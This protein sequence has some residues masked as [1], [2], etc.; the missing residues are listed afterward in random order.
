M[1]TYLITW[2]PKRWSWE[3]LS[4]EAELVR[5]DGFVDD[6]WSC[7]RN[8]K[9]QK[10]DRVFLLR[11][12]M[13]PKG[14]VG[15]GHVIRAPFEGKHWDVSRPNDKALYVGVRFDRILDPESDEVLETSS[16][17]RG[18]LA[19]VYWKTQM[20][21]I[22][23]PDA[24]ASEL[25]AIWSGFSHN[26]ALPVIPEEVVTPSHFIEGA[27]KKV[28]VNVFERNPKARKK[29]IEH[30]G[31]RCSACGFDFEKVYG[32]RGRGFIHVHHLIPL[33]EIGKEYRINPIEDLR[34]V[35]PNCHAMLHLGPEVLNV[36]QLQG[37]LRTHKNNGDK[38]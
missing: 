9:I 23:I 37:L 12:G 32:E 13:E 18:A 19:D 35:C 10:G 20:S 27:T 29:C 24:A 25:E 30:F 21:G 17:A 16:L 3:N 7:G 33:S 26:E 38:P 14:I 28:S 5:R 4:E 36:E 31:A 6:Q 34:P 22:E 8:R 15:S 11:Q 2:N 1:K